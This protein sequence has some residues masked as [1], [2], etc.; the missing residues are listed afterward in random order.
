[1]F[2][3]RSQLIHEIWTVEV[4]NLRFSVIFPVEWIF[5]SYTNET[6]KQETIEGNTHL[7]SLCLVRRT[8]IPNPTT[9]AM[10]ITWKIWTI[11][12]ISHLWNCSSSFVIKAKEDNALLMVLR[13]SEACIIYPW[14]SSKEY[15]LYLHNT[16]AKTKDKVEFQICT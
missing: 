5:S 6:R 15:F 16:E 1:M 9:N 14:F 7:V 4:H 13:L 10:F 8:N 12:T 3:W 2:F 11:T